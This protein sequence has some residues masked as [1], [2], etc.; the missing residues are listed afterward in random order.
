MKKTYKWEICK[1]KSILQSIIQLI[2][3]TFPKHVLNYE[4][5][6]SLPPFFMYLAFHS[7]HAPIQ[8]PL[9]YLEMYN[10]LNETKSEKRRKMMAMVTALD[11]NVGKI[12]QHLKKRDLF[13]N[14]IFLFTSDV[15]SFYNYLYR[16]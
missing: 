1:S 8:V 2:H 11:D 5:D 14:T 9:K 13:D 16:I 10:H 6:A 7:V 4:N 3:E 15:S 12:V